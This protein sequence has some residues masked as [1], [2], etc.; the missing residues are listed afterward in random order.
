M[1]HNPD[2]HPSGPR[3]KRYSGTHPR[4]F[5]ERYKELDPAR[6]PGI[7]EHIRARGRTPAGSHVPVLLNEVLATLAPAPG[8][9]VVDCTVGYG[10]HAR[11]LAEAVAP[12]GRLI[13]LDCDAEELRRARSR[14]M[15]PGVRIS[16]HARNFIA[17]GKVLEIEGVRACDMI[18]ADLGVSSMQLDDPS[19]GMS[20]KHDGPLDMRMDRRLKRTAADVLASISA[21]ELSAA[22]WSYADEPDH[23]RLAREIV[24]RVRRGSLKTTRELSDLVLKVKGYTRAT[25]KRRQ[26][27]EPGVPHPAARTFQ[28]LRMLVNDERAALRE[29]MR[30]APYLLN[31]GGRIGIISFH[32]GEDDCVAEALRWGRQIGW[33]EGGVEEPITPSPRERYDNPRGASA[34][35]RWARR[36]AQ[37]I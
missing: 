5:E 34:R 16:L 26:M 30:Q 15:V 20:Y 7:T 19:R 4:R 10:G 18:F 37:P 6:Y 13:G 2:E 1:I 11:A 36:S 35:F 23:V 27:A 3:R 29:L 32:S 31:P 17:I 21:D 25:W 12:G 28:T 14:L 9:T 33:L 24:A 8:E 22:L